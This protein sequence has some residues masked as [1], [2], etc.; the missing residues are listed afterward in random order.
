MPSC[1]YHKISRDFIEEL[2]TQLQSYHQIA[3]IGPPQS[4]KALLLE[5]LEELANTRNLAHPKRIIWED[6]VSLSE[7]ECIAQLRTFF[8]LVGSAKSDI[9]LAEALVDIIREATENGPIWILLQDILGFCRPIANQILDGL[10]LAQEALPNRFGVVVTGS[11]ELL[12]L[13]HD[14]DGRFKPTQVYFVFQMEEEFAKNYFLKCRRR[15]TPLLSFEEAIEPQAFA[16]LYEETQGIPYLIQ[17]LAIGV[18]RHFYNSRGIEL[19]QQWQLAETQKYITGY[20]KSYLLHDSRFA[21]A[22]QEVELNRV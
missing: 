15:Y 22:L 20:S 9:S 3:V 17:E 6:F 11:K 5:E 14:T 7:T 16:Y 10:R 2:A 19:G 8:D 4:A 13:T 18:G 21:Q 1:Q 12:W